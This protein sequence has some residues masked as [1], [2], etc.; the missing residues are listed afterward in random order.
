MKK[1]EKVMVNTFT[2]ELATLFQAVLKSAETSAWENDR[3]LNATLSTLKEKVSLLTGAINRSKNISQLETID[4]KRDQN[5]RSIYYLN[6]GYTYYHVTE[7]VEAAEQIDKILDKYSL[8]IIEESYAKES[9][10]IESL[11]KDLQTNENMSVVSKLP[12]LLE[13]VQFV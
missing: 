7:V 1:I 11:L 2:T 5:I 9:A 4:R 3:F 8:K 13:G 10:L 12:G 6:K